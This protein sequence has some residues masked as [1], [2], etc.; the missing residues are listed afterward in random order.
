LTNGRS[1]DSNMQRQKT[2]FD[3]LTNNSDPI[4]D[5]TAEVIKDDVWPNPMQYFL[6]PEVEEGDSDEGEEGEGVSDE[7]EEDGDEGE[8]E[9]GSGEAD[10]LE[11]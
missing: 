5:D 9:E 2:F 11:E 1:D 10:E 3:W 8:G 7:D 4:A 6:V